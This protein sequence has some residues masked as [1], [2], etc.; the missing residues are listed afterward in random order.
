[1][2]GKIVLSE[3]KS[4][5][6]EEWAKA[7]GQERVIVRQEY[8][9]YCRIYSVLYIQHCD[10]LANA[11][12]PHLNNFSEIDRLFQDEPTC[13]WHSADSVWYMARCSLFA[14]LLLCARL[15]SAEHPTRL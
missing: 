14:S 8:R 13:T 9:L 1:M 6:E 10:A 4:N 5:K 11:N 2:G 7:Q 3:K 15:T 12:E